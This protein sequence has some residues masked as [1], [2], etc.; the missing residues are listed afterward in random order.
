MKK[1]ECELCGYIYD[2]AVGDDDGGIAPGTS[3]EALPEDWVCPL[4]GA[5]KEDF[6]VYED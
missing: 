2:P 5:G 1:Y 3:F 6:V 4:C